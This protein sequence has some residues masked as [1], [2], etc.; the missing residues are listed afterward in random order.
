MA[1]IQRVSAVRIFVTDLERARV[2]YRDVLE[3]DEMDV[4][5][6]Y[7]LLDCDGISL[8]LETVRTDDPEAAG[9]VGRLLAVSF[10]V[11]GNIHEVHRR[12]VARGVAFEGVPEK[13]PWGGTLA[14]PLDPDGNI[15]TLVG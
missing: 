14:F 8:L 15:L 2:F 7:A 5:D 13:Q 3:L 1:V 6:G 9:L 4:G 12:L 10:T 11:E